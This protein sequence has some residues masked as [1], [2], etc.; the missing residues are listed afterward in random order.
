M[1][2]R[3]KKQI[4]MRLSPQSEIVIQRVACALAF[5]ALDAAERQEIRRK[6]IGLITR[7]RAVRA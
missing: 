6:A 4:T 2:R 7:L 3:K 5:E 1:K